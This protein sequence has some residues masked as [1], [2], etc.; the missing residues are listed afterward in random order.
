MEVIFAY[1]VWEEVSEAQAFYEGEVEGL[2][3]AFI[4]TVFDSIQEIKRY[5]EFYN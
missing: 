1:E 3:K 4:Q 2:G 5:P